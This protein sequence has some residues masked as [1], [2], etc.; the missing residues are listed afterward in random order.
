MG[1]NNKINLRKN[2]EITLR[3]LGVIAAT[4]GIALSL[5]VT[6]FALAKQGIPFKIDRVK[7]IGYTTTIGNGVEETHDSYFVENCENYSEKKSIIIVYDSP[8]SENENN[9][10]IEYDL[11][12]MCDEDYKIL[13]DMVLNND[14]NTLSIY[15]NKRVNRFHIKPIYYDVSNTNR[16][17]PYS[18]AKTIKQNGTSVV[19]KETNKNN[20][21]ATTIMMYMGGILSALPIGYI[22]SDPEEKYKG[23]KYMKKGA[24]SND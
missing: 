1:K 15:L 13:T 22:F 2:V 3:S 17:I 16:S 8:I 11:T 18:L 7:K 24:I 5:T 9:N 10:A 14:I 6:A 23:K 19:E 4:Y 12:Y 20:R 21:T